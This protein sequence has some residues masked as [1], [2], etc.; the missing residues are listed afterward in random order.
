MP[1][2][3]CCFLSSVA[4]FRHTYAICYWFFHGR[5]IGDVFWSYIY[6]R[7]T[8]RNIASLLIFFSYMRTVKKCAIYSIF[9]PAIFVGR[10]AYSGSLLKRTN[11]CD[12]IRRIFNQLQR[13]PLKLNP[14]NW[15]LTKI[16]VR[17]HHDWI[18]VGSVD[19][20]SLVDLCKVSVKFVFRLKL[21]YL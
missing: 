12:Y 18:Q 2:Q 17:M 10:F 1:I 4:I 6:N 15:H 9:N 7:I 5:P 3:T 13:Y 21:M 16:I 19:Y 8:R 11:F 14:E 20:E